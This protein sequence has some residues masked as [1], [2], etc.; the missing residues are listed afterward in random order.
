MNIAKPDKIVVLG[1]MSHFPVAGVVWQTIHYLIGLQRLG[2]NV[3]YVEAHGC[4]PSMLMQSEDDDGPLR[5]AAYVAEIMNRFG[6]SD[7]W[8]Y[9]TRHEPRRFFGMSELQVK[10]LYAEAAVLI[11]LS[12]ATLPLPEHTA[13]DRLVYLETDPVEVQ[14]DL[15]SQKRETIEFLQDHCALFTYGENFG[16]PDCVLPSSDRFQ[17]L[18]TRQPVVMDFWENRGSGGATIFTTVGNW[19]QPGRRRWFGGEVYHWSKHFEFM[20]FISLP[21]HTRQH[22]ELALGSYTEADRQML[23]R[24]GWRVRRALDISK[25]LD[26]EAYRGYVCDS[27]GEFTVA[28][29]QNIRLR[30]GWFS[31]R[32][33][34]YLAVGRPVIT[35]ETGF[36]N[37]LPTGEGLFAFSTM[38]EILAAVDAIN[39]DYPRHRRAAFEIARAYFGHDVVLKRLLREIGLNR[40]RKVRGARKLKKGD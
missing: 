9:D 14:I 27:R 38:D 29:D 17:F 22:F 6:L 35:Q 4:F 25:G 18:P 20:K 21:S 5:A 24:H 3:F 39:S 30:S 11:N 40:P 10:N 19:N 36:S 23:E 7:H 2:Y 31:D 28:K 12:A 33:A 26:F 8:A 37:I 32:S 34:T 16:K 13:T 1:L 15:L